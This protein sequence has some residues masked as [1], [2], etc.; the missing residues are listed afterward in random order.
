MPIILLP[1]TG[2]IDENGNATTYNAPTGEQTNPTLSRYIAPGQ[3]IWVQTNTT[4]ATLTIDK[5]ACTHGDGGVLKS[6]TIASDRDKIRLNLTN[7]SVKDEALIL[8][9]DF[10]S[11]IFTDYDSQKKFSGSA[12]GNLSIIKDGKYT[13]INSLPSVYSEQVVPLSVYFTNF[14]ENN[15]YTLQV[16]ELSGFD[17]NVGIYLID[18]EVEGS[19]IDLRE[20][21]EYSFKPTSALSNSRFQIKVVPGITTDIVDE[22]MKDVSS[23]NIKIFAI[24]QKAI[25]KVDDSTLKGSQKL[26]NVYNVAGQ[27]VFQSEL[28]KLVTEV[29]L[30]QTNTIYIVN[31]VVDGK[32]YQQKVMSQN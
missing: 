8:F 2:L 22:D 28:N 7:G 29:S 9:A 17:D 20:V 13:V 11:D 15:T 18:N 26:I 30:P 31:V 4:G 6:A 32:S 5:T 10:G 1:L 19:K 14:N 16:S 27:L 21:K 12:S 23:N 24:Q 3:S 25:V